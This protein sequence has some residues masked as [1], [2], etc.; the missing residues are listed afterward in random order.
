MKLPESIDPQL[1]D[2]HYRLSPDEWTPAVHELLA[3]H[4]LPL[5]PLRYFEDGSN[6]LASVGDR[7]IVKIFPP[8]HRHQWESEFRVLEHLQGKLSFPIPTLIASGERAD[9]WPFVIISLLQGQT[10]EHTWAETAK[11]D[12]LRILH[13][14]GQWMAEVHQV[15]LGQLA[16]LPPAWEGFLEAQL[17][18]CLARHTRLKA[19]EWLQRQLPEY[20]MANRQQVTTAFEPV[21]LT[22][23]YTPFNLMGESNAQGHRLTGM[24]DFGDAMVGPAHY[25][26]LGPAAFLCE[27]DRDS[28]HALLQGYGLSASQ[29]GGGLRTRLMMLL[30]LHRYSNLGAQV[31]IDGWASRADSIDGL[32]TLLF[33]G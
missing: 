9:G 28:F 21:L 19:P 26:L 18:G 32:A 14:I 24:I 12:R 2:K 29:L 25:D 8:F 7:W 6:L 13:H 16:D 33:P 31:R 22:G 17:A 1:F 23:E 15:P 20:L 3:A 5:G 11:P 10:L 4:Q 30:L 27:G